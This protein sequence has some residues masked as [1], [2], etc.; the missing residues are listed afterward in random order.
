MKRYL[1][2]VLSGV[3]TAIVVSFGNYSFVGG[4]VAAIIIIIM[5]WTFYPIDKYL[6]NK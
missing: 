4:I 5:V 1:M 6:N 2:A 3:I